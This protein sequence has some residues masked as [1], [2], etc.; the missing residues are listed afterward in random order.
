MLIEGSQPTQWGKC[1]KGELECSV[2]QLELREEAVMR[3]RHLWT[4]NTNLAECAKL[5]V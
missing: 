5:S 3:A 1:H 4:R 2:V